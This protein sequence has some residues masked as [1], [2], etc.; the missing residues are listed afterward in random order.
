TEG[1]LRIA[2]SFHN[3]VRGHALVCGRTEINIEDIPFALKLALDSAPEDRTKIFLQLINKNGIM[4]TTDIQEV[5]NCSK[6]TALFKMQELISI[7]ICTESIKSDGG[8]GRK[9]KLVCL[10]EKCSMFSN[11]EFKKLI[12]TTQRQNSLLIKRFVSV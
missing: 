11:D 5:L 3:L 2:S 6:P 10:S 8:V 1:P 9:E 4:A 7:G 12:L